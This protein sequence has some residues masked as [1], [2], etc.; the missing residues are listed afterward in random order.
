MAARRCYSICWFGYPPPGGKRYILW[1]R[2]SIVIVFEWWKLH[3][4][5]L[6]LYKITRKMFILDS[7]RK[8]FRIAIYVKTGNFQCKLFFAKASFLYSLHILYSPLQKDVQKKFATCRSICRLFHRTRIWVAKSSEKQDKHENS[9]FFIGW[10]MTQRR[11]DWVIIPKN[12]V[13]TDE[14]K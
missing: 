14:L 7:F 8:W 3:V 2:W 12:H 13:L 6:L 11:I 10:L 4:R 5:F 1:V 9:S